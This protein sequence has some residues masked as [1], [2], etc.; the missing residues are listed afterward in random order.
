MIVPALTAWPAYLLIP[1][2]FDCESRPFFAAPPFLRPT[3]SLRHFHPND[4]LFREIVLQISYASQK[5]IRHSPKP[6]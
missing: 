6:S 4:N 1:S 2:L 3:S 5:K